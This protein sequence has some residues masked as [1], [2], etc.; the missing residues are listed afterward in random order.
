MVAARK[1]AQRLAVI[2]PSFN[3]LL[4]GSLRTRIDG[5]V[6][7]CRDPKD[8]MVLECARNAEASLIVT[9]DKDLLTL[10]SFEGIHIVTA[11]QYIEGVAS[12]TLQ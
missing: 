7:I 2:M 9:G 12:I 3:V 10:G 1:F 11:S 6:K 5:T 4:E 8:N